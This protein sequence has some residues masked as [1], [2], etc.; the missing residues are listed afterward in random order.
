MP[1]SLC[2]PSIL[3]VGGQSRLRWEKCQKSRSRWK[4]WVN[5]FRSWSGK[6]K[7]KCG[8]GGEE[9]FRN[10]ATI[11]RVLGSSS[12][13]GLPMWA[14]GSDDTEAWAAGRDVLSDVTKSGPLKQQRSTLPLF[15]GHH[16]HL[17]KAMEAW[18]LELPT[19]YHSICSL[20]PGTRQD[21]ERWEFL[22]LLWNIGL[23]LSSGFAFSNKLFM[24]LWLKCQLFNSSCHGK[25][26]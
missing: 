17:P 25:W 1:L 15:W 13:V 26:D 21:R 6:K 20:P 9:L 12:E 22:W 14:A 8:Y 24:K 23:W 19:A 7:K 5:L 18:S 3:V 2:G 4:R 11:V 16:R 10:K